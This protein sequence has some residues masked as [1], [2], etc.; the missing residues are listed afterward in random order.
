MRGYI[1]PISARGVHLSR[2]RRIRRIRRA[3]STVLSPCRRRA[4]SLAAR[5]AAAMVAGVGGVFGTLTYPHLILPY[6]A[7]YGHLV[8]HCGGPQCSHIPWLYAKKHLKVPEPHI[9]GKM[10]GLPV[11]NVLTITLLFGLHVA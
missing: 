8:S 11:P 6:S 7:Y 1:Q 5:A 9:Y 10:G 2:A 3:G 4:R